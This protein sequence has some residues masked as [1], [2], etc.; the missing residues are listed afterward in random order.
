LPIK[1]GAWPQFKEQPHFAGFFLPLGLGL[2]FKMAVTGHWV[3]FF[4]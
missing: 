3:P 2:E 4:V 1:A